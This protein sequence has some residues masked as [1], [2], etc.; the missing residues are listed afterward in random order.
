[1]LWVG[2]VTEEVLLN[3]EHPSPDRCRYANMN[4]YESVFDNYQWIRRHY[5]A[6]YKNTICFMESW[7][8][9][10]GTP[11]CHKMYCIRASDAYSPVAGKR[12][13]QKTEYQS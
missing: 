1:M 13:E 2:D 3:K 11:V 12:W 9:N 8:K 5:P 10:F 4:A 7:S 6:Y